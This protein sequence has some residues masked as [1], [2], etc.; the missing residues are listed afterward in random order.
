MDA[1]LTLTFEEQ[2][3]IEEVVKHYPD[4]VAGLQTS[5]ASLMEHVIEIFQGIVT[6]EAQADDLLVQLIDGIVTHGGPAP[7]RESTAAE[8]RATVVGNL[9]T[10]HL[11]SQ[12]RDAVVRRLMVLRRAEV[13]S[14]QP[15]AVEGVS[16]GDHQDGA[17]KPTG[18][19]QA[20]QGTGVDSRPVSG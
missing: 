9:I 4:L 14:R 6:T 1:R 20:H 13:E 15:T 8:L 2:A 3:H 18:R 17:L 10:R 12:A 19:F 7:Q 11:V 16:P 5:V